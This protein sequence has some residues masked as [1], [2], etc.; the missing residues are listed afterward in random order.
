MLSNICRNLRIVN[1]ITSSYVTIVALSSSALS[2]SKVDSTMKQLIKSKNYT[3]VIDLYNRQSEA[4]SEIGLNLVLKA[5][6]KLGDYAS[7]IR[8]HQQLSLQSRQDSSI[9]TSLI[10]L[11]SKKF[12]SSAV[13]FYLEQ[14]KSIEI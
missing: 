6:T 8:I 12:F 1:Q 13:N 14:R 7:G 3:Q 5:C 4:C 9:Q 10:H 11:Y 2:W